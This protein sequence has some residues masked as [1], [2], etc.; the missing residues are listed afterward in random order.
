MRALVVRLVDES[1]ADGSPDLASL[2]QVLVR[3]GLIP[4]RF[5]RGFGI[6]ELEQEILLLIYKQSRDGSAREILGRLRSTAA[7]VRDRLSSDTWAILSQLDSDARSRP[8]SVPLAGAL[9]LLNSA[10]VD[11]SAFSGM[12][13]ENMTRGLGWRFL[14]LGRRLERAMKLLQLFRA[15]IC[16]E[17]KNSFLLEVVLEISDSVMTYRRRYFSGV[18]LL[19]LLELLLLDDGNPRSLAFQLNA[20]RD[21]ILHL[22]REAGAPGPCIEESHI[23]QICVLLGKVNISELGAA[24]AG[25]NEPLD[26]VLSDLMVEL[27][28]LSN[29]LTHHY[30][31]HT[32]ASVS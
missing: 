20:L 17:G 22:P 27:G 7:I 13:M 5:E 31:T 11:L 29:Q 21:H 32:V 18:Q 16:H 19:A 24:D 26:A 10:I 8:R 28:V 25:L 9:R 4:A 30:F 3:L 12:E 2:A 23:L 15:S 14:D 6:K 1:V